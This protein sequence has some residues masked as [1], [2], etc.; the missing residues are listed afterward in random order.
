M[1]NTNNEYFE[2]ELNFMRDFKGSEVT[3]KI[4]VFV[5][6]AQSCANLR[7]F[8]EVKHFISGCESKFD[9]L[10]ISET[11]I[12]F[13]EIE[14]YA[15]DGYR[16]FH[17]CRANR[18]GGGLSIFVK[19]TYDVTDVEIN[20]IG[21]E[22]SNIKCLST[23]RIVGVYRPPDNRN[24][25]QTMAKLES[26]L[27]DSR[28]K[29]IMVAGDFNID[30]STN[31][32]ENR[33]LAKKYVNNMKSYGLEL[34]NDVITRES[35]GTVIDHIFSSATGKYRHSI[36]TI[37]CSFSDHNIIV[38]TI[39]TGN[40]G[41]CD[42]S[43]ERK[44]IDYDRLN[45]L[46]RTRLADV[47]ACNN[48]INEKT[49]QLVNCMQRS[50]A[51]A[52]TTR[53]IKPRHKAMC[54]W[55]DSSPHIVTM[56][57]E[58]NN[59]WRKN[60]KFLRD[61]KDNQHILV[62]LKDIT[63]K[64]VS[65]KALAKEKF[66]STKFASCTTSKETWKTINEVISTGKRKER[67]HV[68]LEENGAAVVKTLVA[69]SFAEY[70]STV[71]NRLADEIETRPGDAQKVIES[72]AS[73][74][75]SIFLTPATEDE[76]LLLINALETKKAAGIDNIHASTIKNCAETIVPLLT[77]IIND[78]I[79]DGIYPDALKIARVVPIFKT[80][81]KKII[82]N[83]RPISILPIFN[84][85]FERV[86]YNRLEKFIEKNKILY[87]CQYG[88]RRKCG[89]NTALSEIVDMLQCQMNDWKTKCTGLFMDLSK[90]FDCVDHKILLD[91]LHRMGI[92]GI[93]F[94]LLKSYLSNRKIVV[95]VNDSISQPRTMN[96]GVPQGSVLGPILYLL[97]VN[98][99]AALQLRGKLKL[100]ADDSSV[101]YASCSFEQNMIKLRD[102][103]PKIAEYFR[104]NRL[105]LNLRKT[106]YVHF[107]YSRTADDHRNGVELA[108]TRIEHA[109]KVKYLGLVIDRHMSWEKHI[110]SVC[111]KVSGAIGALWK[112]SF[113]PVKILRNLYYA[114]VHPH[115][116]Y[117]AVIWTQA[118]QTHLQRVQVLQRKALKCCYKLNMRF[119]SIALFCDTAKTV[120]P[121]KA[122]GVLQLCSI[123]HS[124][125]KQL[126]KTNF[127]FAYAE[128][129]RSRRRP[130]PMLRFQARNGYGESAIQCRGPKEYDALPDEIKNAPRM[131][132][133]KARLKKFLLSNE[134]ITKFI[135]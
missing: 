19:G 25:E 135:H 22:I 85:V 52:T 105:T 38:A 23:F 128:N 120:L 129:H 80:G 13:T 42:L 30:L 8:D 6:N 54:E 10:I 57:R 68:S 74:D 116:D 46:L 96:I 115:L 127:T 97:Y 94:D 18:R 45:E 83:Y 76:I 109:D 50:I 75:Q 73:N 20:M 61:G 103:L 33:A 58:K 60:K 101:F 40:D 132:T 100:F 84:N 11:W 28:G 98:D 95:H 130:I 4:A 17:S 81:S 93:A 77:S 27:S 49:A 14:L 112:L 32:T 66:Y 69:E 64:L 31:N 111:A 47:A 113:L 119:D 59:L 41:R 12:K 125:V 5:V 39:E 43:I 89:T 124:S 62:R 102:D 29:N 126:A 134:I 36:D 37:K 90:A 9:I 108:G 44:K 67:L 121:L 104:L 15:I 55:I 117:A 7:T 133:F 82:G 123:V 122:I 3:K 92:R 107:G 91:K 78:C 34:C 114:I 16:G 131:N 110:D 99:I 2:S 1:V 70:F 26:I 88:F 48:G 65:L 72:I 53:R 63:R 106:N 71:G 51:E 56:T 87:E 21:I 24:L 35:S 118:A 79:S 86:I